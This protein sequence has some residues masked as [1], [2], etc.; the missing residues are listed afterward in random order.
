[1]NYPNYSSSIANYVWENIWIVRVCSIKTN[2]RGFASAITRQKK[3]G[4]IVMQK[5]WINFTT[6]KWFVELQKQLARVS[7]YK[8]AKIHQ[9][10]RATVDNR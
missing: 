2:R 6:L 3:F 8:D 7:A 9:M 4:E 1:M 10:F 5:G